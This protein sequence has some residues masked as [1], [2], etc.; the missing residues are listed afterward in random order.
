ME[1]YELSLIGDCLVYSYEVPSPRHLQERT[2]KK[3]KKK[4]PE[5][6]H[7]RGKS[8]VKLKT[9]FRRLFCVLL[10][11][12]ALLMDVECAVFKF[13]LRTA[14]ILVRRYTRYLPL[15][16]TLCCFVILTALLYFL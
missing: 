12:F 14:E 1:H 16:G 2:P 11:P 4:A 3:E 7:R 15:I 8:H 5:R 10:F 13:L 6:G 9:F